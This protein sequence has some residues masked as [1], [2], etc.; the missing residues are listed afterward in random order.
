MM[1]LGDHPG[2]RAEVHRTVITEEAKVMILRGM[3]GGTV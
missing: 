2:A 3:T 1:K